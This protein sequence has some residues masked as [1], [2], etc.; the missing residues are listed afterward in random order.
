VLFLAKEEIKKN[1]IINILFVCIFQI[2]LT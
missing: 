2:R 1:Y